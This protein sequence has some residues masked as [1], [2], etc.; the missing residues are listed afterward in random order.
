MFC[1][2][3]CQVY[4][5]MVEQPCPS[6]TGTPI[7]LQF[8][9]LSL[10]KVEPSLDLGLD[11]DLASSVQDRT[12]VVKWAPTFPDAIPGCHNEHFPPHFH[13]LRRTNKLP[14][15]MVRPLP[16][17]HAYLQPP[18]HGSKCHRVALS[19]IFAT[20]IEDRATPSLT[21]F[22][23]RAHSIGRLRKCAIRSNVMSMQ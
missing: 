14:P 13:H 18:L 9:V 4:V 2:A 11:L 10:L 22:P 15:I 19:R 21:H 20:P 8:Q 7:M 5:A 1:P 16:L 6:L 3:W 23:L 12:S 17:P